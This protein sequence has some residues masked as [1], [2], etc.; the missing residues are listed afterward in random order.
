MN[1]LFEED[2]A[3]KAGAVLA[4]NVTSLQVELASGK[5]SK[6]KAAN[7]LLRFDAPAPADLL[8]RAERDAADIDVDFLWE[9]CPDAEFGFEEFAAEYAGHKPTAV[10]AAALLL[11]LHS[12]PM[13]FHRKG[14]GRFR[15][16]PPEILQAALAGQ[17]KKRQQVLAI[18]RM[19]EELKAGTLPAECAAILPQLLYKPDRN[20]PETKALEAACADTALSAPRLLRRCGALADTHEYHL[21]RFLFEYFPAGTEFPPCADPIEPAGLPVAGVR[22]FSIDDAHTTEIDDAFSLVA[23]PDGGMRV[24]IH[25]AAPG[26]GISPDSDLGRLARNR[27]STVYMPGRK[28]TMLPEAVVERFTLGAGK[29]AP[30]VSLYLDV[31]ADLAVR[32]HQTRLESVPVVANLRHHDIEPLFNEATLATGLA[33]FPF[34]TELKRL[35]ELATVLEAGRGQ[36]RNGPQRKDYNFVVDWSAASEDGPGI[37]AIDERPRGSPLDTL[38]AELMIVANATWGAMLRDAKVAALYRA[39]TVGKVR[40]TTAAAPHEGLGVDCYAWSSSP[41]R[42]HVDLINQWQLIAHLGNDPPPFTA[43]S[44]E[45]LAALR[46]FELTY[47]AYADFQRGMENYWCLRWLRQRQE[48]AVT[49]RVLRE[50]LVRLEHLPLVLKVPS[51]PALDRGARVRLAIESIDLLDAECRARFVEALP[52]EASD[53]ATGDTVEEDTPE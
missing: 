13:Y 42:R 41:L 30:A 18:E 19:V 8:D 47:A 52:A 31:G 51:L 43:K 33:D 1:V 6:V 50:S 40:M 9:M 45:L 29:T 24:G 21:G 27:L 44:A 37:V 12:A 32:G 11:R 53:D 34:A 25:I 2:G 22:A 46:D 26:L 48:S 49:A 20:R 5:R 28:I 23:L 16:A 36:T 38:V 3:F 35:W 7:V 39:Q 17:E 10:E 15:K 14:K 4:D